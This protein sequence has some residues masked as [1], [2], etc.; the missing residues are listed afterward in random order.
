M[1]SP[2]EE[3][4]ASKS[5]PKRLLKAKYPPCF[6][7][8]QIMSRRAVERPPNDKFQGGTGRELHDMPDFSF[9]RTYTQFEE[10]LKLRS[11]PYA[12]KSKQT[13]S[14]KAKSKKSTQAQ[15]GTAKSAT[16]PATTE[17]HVGAMTGAQ[18]AVLSK[19]NTP[20]PDTAVPSSL[21][22][23]NNSTNRTVDT[24]AGRS[25]EVGSTQPAPSHSMNPTTDRR[26]VAMAGL[27]DAAATSPRCVGA[28]TPVPSAA[29]HYARMR[30]AGRGTSSRSGLNNSTNRTVH[31]YAG[32]SHEVEVIGPRT[33]GLSNRMNPTTEKHTTAMD[34]FDDDTATSPKRV[35]A[36]TSH[37]QPPAPQIGLVQQHNPHDHVRTTDGTRGNEEGEVGRRPSDDHSTDIRS[38]GD[39]VP[40]DSTTGEVPPGLEPFWDA[41]PGLYIQRN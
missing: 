39:A 7:C 23:L 19:V 11:R 25:H 26:T 18:E 40:A 38:A 34:E 8:I 17:S 13:K 5:N 33:S 16:K 9:C 4:F 3:V 12:P 28:D 10:E 24:Y 20:Q 2:N 15:T 31:T 37:P 32:R 30:S 21:S 27:D 6:Y 22:G 41:I 29:E 14:K 36:G 35:R 1:A